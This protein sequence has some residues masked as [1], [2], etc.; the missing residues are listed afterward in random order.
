MTSPLTE[1]ELALLL[2]VPTHWVRPMD[3]GGSNR[4]THSATL[5]ALVAKGYVEKCRRDSL[6]NDRGSKRGSYVYR[7]VREA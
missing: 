4:S 2:D 3:L 6:A 5:R 7:K 1:R